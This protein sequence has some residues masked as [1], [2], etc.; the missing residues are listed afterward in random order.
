MRDNYLC[1]D[2]IRETFPPVAICSLNLQYGNIMA[3]NLAH[4]VMSHTDTAR[5]LHNII[6]NEIH[7]RKVWFLFSDYCVIFTLT[8]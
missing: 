3:L 8:Y 4:S 2:F 1:N 6:S 7:Y 5:T